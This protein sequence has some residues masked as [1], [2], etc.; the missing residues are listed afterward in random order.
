MQI[1]KTKFEDLTSVF[2]DTTLSSEATLKQE[3]R[4][5]REQLCEVLRRLDAMTGEQGAKGRK[6][7][8]QSRSNSSRVSG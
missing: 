7:R 6:G 8:K 4:G 5:L 3:I 2:P 1:A